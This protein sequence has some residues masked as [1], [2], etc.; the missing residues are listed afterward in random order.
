MTTVV[1]IKA[2]CS[3]DKEVAVAV[4]DIIDDEPRI[5]ETFEIQDGETAERLAYDN[6]QISIQEIYKEK[7]E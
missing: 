5:V 7:A 4:F 2:H 6:R 3:P 1:T